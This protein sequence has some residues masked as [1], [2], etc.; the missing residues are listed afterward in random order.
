MSGSSS[1]VYL[2][3]INSPSM[4]WNCWIASCKRGSL[5]GL[6]FM[7][8]KA[9][10]KAQQREMRCLSPG[11]EAYSLGGCHKGTGGISWDGI[12][13]NILE[14]TLFI[15]PCHIAKGERNWSLS[16]LTVKGTLEAQ[17]ASVFCTPGTCQSWVCQ[18]PIL[19]RSCLINTKGSSLGCAMIQDTAYESVLKMTMGSPPM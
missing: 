9:F 12:D 3:C 14:I 4:I 2:M 19:E 13:G 17:L 6:T 18:T 15:F 1:V 16:G 8:S 11:S 5:P 7:L 10:S